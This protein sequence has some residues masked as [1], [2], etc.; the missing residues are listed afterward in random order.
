VICNGV[1]PRAMAR[2]NE[3]LDLKDLS[4]QQKTA[5]ADEWV[6]KYN[7]LNDQFDAAKKE[8]AAKGED[9]S[10]VQTAQDLLHQGKLEEARKIYDR[11]I[12]SDEGN[13]DRAAQHYFDRATI[14]SLQFHM[15]EALPDYEK[16][17]RYR[18]NNPIY[19]AGYAAT[20]YRERS[21]KEAER[22]ST[23]CLQLYRDLAQ[24]DPGARPY[25][26]ATL[27]N[28]A[29]LY[30]DTGRLA[31]AETAFTEALAVYRDLAQRDPGAYRPY[32]AQTLNNLAILYRDSGRLADAET[33]F[34]EALA[35]YRDLARDNPNVYASL[36]MSVNN[37]LSKLHEQIP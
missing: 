24:R 29:I 5:E 2:L 13:V 3:L 18:P 16:A 34:T 25:V 4:L 14:L 11:L 26:A 12:A 15:V 31:D 21:Y 8:L 9:A 28:L 17:Y 22:G 19:A 1:D 27:N 7:L 23:N 10:L 35:I 6:R 33:A 36:A 20:A 30:H 37:Q 32:V